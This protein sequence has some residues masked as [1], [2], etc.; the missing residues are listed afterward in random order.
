M[1]MYAEEA[2]AA[3]ERAATLV[4]SGW[5][6]GTYAK[7]RD[8]REV[9]A[10]SPEA[11]SWCLHGALRKA[12]RELCPD[13]EGRQRQ[14]RRAVLIPL[15]ALCHPVG[16]FEYNDDVAKSGAEVAGMIRKAAKR[17]VS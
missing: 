6:Q 10:F 12:A 2:K 1:T 8:G 14:V 4:E 9:A 7:N 5:T 16:L 11:A 3:A 15:R 17:I 13:D